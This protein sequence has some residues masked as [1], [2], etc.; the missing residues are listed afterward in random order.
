MGTP[1]RCGIPVTPVASGGIPEAGQAMEQ[2]GR[3]VYTNPKSL[4]HNYR[5]AGGPS[6]PVHLDAAE[7]ESGGCG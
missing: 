6:Q 7:Q 5:G 3:K 2:A 4:V 1:T